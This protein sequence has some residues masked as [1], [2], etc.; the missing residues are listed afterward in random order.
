MVRK[1]HREEKKEEERKE[2]EITENLNRSFG[3]DQKESPVKGEGGS[4]TLPLMTFAD[5]DEM[6]EVKKQYENDEEKK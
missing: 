6:K 5:S 2:N 3:K 4:K 1:D